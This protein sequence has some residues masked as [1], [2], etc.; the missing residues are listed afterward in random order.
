MDDEERDVLAAYE[1]ALGYL[2]QPAPP[3][4]WKFPAGCRERGNYRNP[5]FYVIDEGGMSATPGVWEWDEFPGMWGGELGDLVR[6]TME[7]HERAQCCGW[8]YLHFRQMPDAWFC[9]DFHGPAPAGERPL[10]PRPGDPRADPEALR[11][12]AARAAIASRGLAPTYEGDALAKAADVAAIEKMLATERL[13]GVPPLS[14][15]AAR[16]MARAIAEEPFWRSSV[17]TR[18]P[19]LQ[20]TPLGVP[21]RYAEHA[22]VRAAA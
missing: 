4:M 7:K 22:P 10:V 3:V 13:D 6:A 17:L 18:W 19:G 21:P 9:F 15:K 14:R 5:V 12:R 8:L 16:E 20:W 11:L 2:T 1:K